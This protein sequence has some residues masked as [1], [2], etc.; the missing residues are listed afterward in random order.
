MRAVCRLC[1]TGIAQTMYILYGYL[2]GADA[3]VIVN[4]MYFFVIYGVY[5]LAQK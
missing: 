4:N 5:L 3:I 1:D 2:R